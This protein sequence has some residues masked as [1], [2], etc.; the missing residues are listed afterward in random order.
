MDN[1]SDYKVGSS[2][3]LAFNLASVKAEKIRFSAKPTSTGTVT[4]HEIE[5]SGILV[6]KYKKEVDNLL[7]GVTFVPSEE[8]KNNVYKYGDYVMDFD[9]LTDGEMTQEIEGRFSS[10]KGGAVEATASLNGL[11]ALSEIRIY[12]YKGEAERAGKNFKLEVYVGGEW[13][14]V[15][16]GDQTEIKKNLTDRYLSFDMGY[17]VAEK[18]RFSATPLSSSET[19]TFYEIEASGFMLE[20]YELGELENNVLLGKQFAPT[21]EANAQIYNSSYGYQNLTEGANARFSTKKNTGFVDA[22]LDLGGTYALE[23][24]RIRYYIEGSNTTSFVGTSMLIQVY[25]NGEWV[26]VVDCKSPSEIVSHRD[27]SRTDFWLSFDL[28]D[29]L[30]EKV[31]IY[32]PSCQSGYSISYYEIESS[33]R[34]LIDK[35]TVI[36]G[37][38]ILSG[39]N[40]NVPI[41]V[42]SSSNVLAGKTFVPTAEASSQIYN[43]NYGYANLTDGSLSTRYSSKNKTGI[44]DATLDLGGVYEL[45]ELNIKYYTELPSKGEFDFVGTA[46]TVEIYMMG[47]WETVV[48]CSSNSEISEHKTSDYWLSF[49]L[50]GKQAEKIRIYIPGCVNV[51]SGRSISLYEI[52]CSGKE[53]KGGVISEK[54]NV[55]N[56]KDSNPDTYL[57]VINT[58]KYSLE[59]ELDR[60]RALTTLNIFE[61]IEEENLINGVLFTASS[62]TDVEVFT[63]GAWV[64]IYDNVT[65]GDGFTSFYMYKVEA[66]KIRITFENTRLFDG[67]TSLRTAK[68]S[69]ITCTADDEALDYTEM[70]AA[71]DKFPETHYGNQ[72]YDKFCGYVLDFNATQAEI[73]AY[74]A[75]IELYCEITAQTSFTPKTSITLGSELVYNVYVPQ[76]DYL[77]SFTIDDITYENPKIVTLDGGDQYYHIAVPM[78]ASESARN[79]VLKVVITIDG[80]DY[81]GTYTMNIPKYAK[82]VI[83]SSNVEEEVILVKDVLAYIKAAYIYFDAVDKTE[84]VKAIDEILGDYNNTFAKVE[85]NT[86]ADD[87]LWGVVIALEEKP[88]VRF[89]L[90][91]GVT[92]DGYTFKVGNTVLDFTT[93]TMTVEDKTYNYAE[94][95]LYA[96]QMIREITYTNGTESGCYHINSYYDYVTTDNELKSD[97][98]LISL[99]EKLYN[100]CKSAEDY[101]ALV[102]NK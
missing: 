47:A 50:G 67:E 80:N 26:D 36:T 11:Y 49:D 66:T 91:E 9:L 10:T 46:L 7:S 62:S 35:T 42:E 69:E 27:T 30:A 74:A 25:R 52:E 84:V 78:A 53:L 20:Q 93:G 19:V 75:E 28:W 86:D 90:P 83:K 68:I 18:I 38:N 43:S 100:Y 98:N 102:T 73:D 95:S 97:A 37:K 96:Y 4:F 55:A 72:T 101:R 77:K 32:V 13:I 99:V 44:V 6:Q 22:T 71:L 87:G 23:E 29:V 1:A 15:F 76:V 17:A 54:N 16:S 8:T 64:K 89:V 24:L 14:T 60:P 82:K 12:L 57:E 2:P 56:V 70:K 33:A 39:A 61:L 41:E 51:G 85:G 92:T 21:A 79:I 5:C 59:I 94:V 3:Y 40:V 34:K 45:N 63:K 31:R 81:N 88:V 65:L 58:N 48:S